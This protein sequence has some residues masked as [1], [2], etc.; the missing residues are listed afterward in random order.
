LKVKLPAAVSVE[1]FTTELKVDEGV[2][3]LHA[4]VEVDSNK[5]Q[6]TDE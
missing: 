6:F 4:T 3:E 5:I 1:G 2:P